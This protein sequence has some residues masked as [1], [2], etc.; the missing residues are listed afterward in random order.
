MIEI[1]ID[2]KVQK[3]NTEMTIELYQTIQKNPLKYTNP[4]EML[5]LYLGITVEELKDLP[6]DQ[7]RFVEGV[8]SSHILRPN[9]DDVIYTFQLDGVTYGLENDW[10]N[11]KW[12]QWVD[13]EVFSQ[14]DK[15]T[16]SIHIIMALLYRPVVVEKGTEYKL[17]DFKSAEVME[18]AEMFRKNLPIAYWFGCANFFFLIAKE[19]ITNIENS[20]KAKMKLI[21]LMKPITKILPKWLHPK[22]LRDSTS[23]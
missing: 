12:G 16:D 1:L 22:V 19:F 4:S 13:L 14:Q 15:I 5:A 3:V 23:T 20:T 11:M 18:R 6:V 2:G 17:V 8:L 21:R 10:G 9:P 7:I